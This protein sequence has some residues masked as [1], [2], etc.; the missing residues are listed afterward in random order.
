[1][2]CQVPFNW[3]AFN[4]IATPIYRGKQSRKQIV[5]LLRFARNDRQGY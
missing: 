2:L 4:V 5:R 3:M 1:M